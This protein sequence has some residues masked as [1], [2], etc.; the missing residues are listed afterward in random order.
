M[1]AIRMKPS[2]P[3]AAAAGA[4]AVLTPVW[5]WAQ[6][7]AETYGYGPGM[8]WRWGWLGM[9]FGPL[10]MIL[11]L[12]VV[13]VAVVLVVRWIGGPWHSAGL[14][15]TVSPSQRALEILNERFA[16]DEIDSAEYEEKRRMI[17]Q[18]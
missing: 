14:P 9:F 8:M 2:F 5:A 13:I 7:T 6:T 10:F 15:P 1:E 17:S 16:R 3:F 4:T 11:P 18:G 12:A